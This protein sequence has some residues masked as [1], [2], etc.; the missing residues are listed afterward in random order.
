MIHQSW[1]FLTTQN[2]NGASELQPICFTTQLEHV[3]KFSTYAHIILDTDWIHSLL[4]N[5]LCFLLNRNLMRRYSWVAICVVHAYIGYVKCFKIW[6]QYSVPSTSLLSRLRLWY[7]CTGV[8]MAVVIPVMVVALLCAALWFCWS[9][10]RIRIQAARG[11]QNLTT[12]QEVEISPYPTTYPTLP[13]TNALDQHA[14]WCVTICCEI[15]V[16]ASCSGAFLWTHTTLKTSNCTVCMQGKLMLREVQ[17]SWIKSN[18][19]VLEGSEYFI[20]C[21]W[22]ATPWTHCGCCCLIPK[23]DFESFVDYSLVLSYTVVTLYI[24][25]RTT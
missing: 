17:F 8:I 7:S 9:F 10:I 22:H 21:G 11:I 14:I 24:W 25:R 18:N 13:A 3:C 5:M 16:V 2:C 12:S 23:L 1:S 15:I 6:R 19:Q 4:Q 20:V